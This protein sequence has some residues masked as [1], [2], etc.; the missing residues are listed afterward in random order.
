[1]IKEIEQLHD[2]LLDNRNATLEELIQ[3]LENKISEFRP[4]NHDAT[5]PF[6]ACNI[7]KGKIAPNLN[8]D[9]TSDIVEV[10]EQNFSKRDLAFMLAALNRQINLVKKINDH[11][12]KLRD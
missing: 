8:Y 12:K 7:K 11:V 2:L 6:E 10:L 4:F 1:M 9:R 5:I 3:I